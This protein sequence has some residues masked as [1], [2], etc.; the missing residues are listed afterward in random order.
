MK[1]NVALLT[2]EKRKMTMNEREYHDLEILWALY[3]AYKKILQ[4]S[5]FSIFTHLF[6]QRYISSVKSYISIKTMF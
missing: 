2:K 1:N 5:S 3:N 6:K 4:D